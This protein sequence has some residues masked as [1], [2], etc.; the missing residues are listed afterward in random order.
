MSTRIAS[1]TGDEERGGFEPY[2]WLRLLVPHPP[3]SLPAPPSYASRLY[4]PLT[5]KSEKELRNWGVKRCGEE[6]NAIKR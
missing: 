5:V 3:F 6:A 2:V 1:W 4:K